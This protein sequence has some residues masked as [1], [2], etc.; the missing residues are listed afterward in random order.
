MMP[1]CWQC[2]AAI[3]PAVRV[4]IIQFT[5]SPT[6]LSLVLFSAVL[7]TM[8]LVTGTSQH[9]AGRLRRKTP[10]LQ[11][12]LGLIMGFT[13]CAHPEVIPALVVAFI[14]PPLA[15][16]GG[17]RQWHHRGQQGVAQYG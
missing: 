12:V 6:R 15:H 17:C 5:N 8:M 14:N 4:V 16:S 10:S 11:S 3:A 1:Y 7:A 9:C 2:S 13:R